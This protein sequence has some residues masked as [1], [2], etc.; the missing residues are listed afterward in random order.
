[1][2]AMTDQTTTNNEPS[3]LDQLLEHNLTRHMQ[4]EEVLWKTARRFQTL[5]EN[6][7]DIVVILD[8]EGTFRYVS[9][10]AKKILGYDPAD[11]VGTSF[12]E[13]THSDDASTISEFFQAA[14]QH[15][16]AGLRE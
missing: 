13:I 12:Y 14:L 2:T 3:P 8:A 16:G 7:S 1:M 4:L 11:L 10:S 5:I 6:S 15:P 9:R